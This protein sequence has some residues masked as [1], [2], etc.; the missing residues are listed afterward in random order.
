MQADPFLLP[1]IRNLGKAVRSQVQENKTTENKAKYSGAP[2]E[3]LELK[4]LRQEGFHRFEVSS[5]YKSRAFIKNSQS[6]P[7]PKKINKEINSKSGVEGLP[8]L[9]NEFKLAWA[10]R[11]PVKLL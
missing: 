5:S 4:K 1:R 9:H 11:N 2:L 8:H 6:V 10:T 3:S 7:P